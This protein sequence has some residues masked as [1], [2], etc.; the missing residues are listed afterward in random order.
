MPNCYENFITL[1]FNVW[2]HVVMKKL[3]QKVHKSAPSTDHTV[4]NAVLEDRSGIKYKDSYREG[5]EWGAHFS[6]CS[7]SLFFQA[8]ST[9]FKHPKFLAY[10]FGKS[11]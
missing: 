1:S 5:Q 3:K 9:C 7:V 2:A 4:C 10:W 8:Q 6:H 11:Y